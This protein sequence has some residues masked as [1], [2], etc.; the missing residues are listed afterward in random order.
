MIKP[1]TKKYTE[2]LL[3]LLESENVKAS[4]GIK[5]VRNKDLSYFS[6]ESGSYGLLSHASKDSM[7]LNTEHINPVDIAFHVYSIASSQLLTGG[8]RGIYSFHSIGVS[9]RF[10]ENYIMKINEGVRLASNA[11]GTKILGAEIYKSEQP[12]LDITI[13]GTTDKKTH[14]VKK[15]I[16]GGNTIY[17]TGHTGDSFAGQQLLK[18][19]ANP[20]KFERSLI[21]KFLKP[22]LYD[23]VIDSIMEELKPVF[24]TNLSDSIVESL[25]KIAPGPK[26]GF[27]INYHDFPI[28]DDMLQYHAYNR[29]EAFKAALNSPSPNELILIT[30]KPCNTYKKIKNTNINCIG[31]INYDGHYL[32]THK[33]KEPFVP[34]DTRSYNV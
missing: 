20:L 8:C 7:K 23:N 5:S 22:T 28:S 4:S 27:T 26:H 14:L 1:S 11:S 29:L 16:K 33:D 6:E 19:V 25:L 9:D 12:A 3:A 18:N 15:T 10:S 24:V 17:I 13:Y 34:T 2:N 21:N 31:S 30:N 32:E